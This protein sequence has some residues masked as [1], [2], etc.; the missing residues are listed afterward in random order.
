MLSER[1]VWSILK[2]LFIWN[3]LV[4]FLLVDLILGYLRGLGM[5]VIFVKE[6]I[7]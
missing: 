7:V 6:F 4:N 5:R 1:I 2:F 3:Y